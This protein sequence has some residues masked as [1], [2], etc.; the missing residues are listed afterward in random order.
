MKTVYVGFL[1]AAVFTAGCDQP[2]PAFIVA[3]QICGRITF[4]GEPLKDAKVVFVPQKLMSEMREIIPLA[5][6]ITDSGG[7]FEMKSSAGTTN[8]QPGE[9]RVI[10]SKRMDPG[11]E[12]ARLSDLVDEFENLV[13]NDLA[14]FR[15]K[16]VR[17][18]KLPARYNED[19]ILTFRV[20]SDAKIVTANFDLTR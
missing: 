2:Q 16:I 14:M 10:I 7:N 18:E 3:P 20:E 11:Q 17:N 19:T 4:D 13:P 15:S 9:Y 1:F 8:I 6:G 12:K 5:Y